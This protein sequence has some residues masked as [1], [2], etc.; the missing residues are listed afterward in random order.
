VI[1]DEDDARCIEVEDDARCIRIEDDV[2]SIEDAY[3]IVRVSTPVNVVEPISSTPL[4]T[5]IDASFQ[6]AWLRVQVQ[7]HMRCMICMYIY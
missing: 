2:G 4:I 7:M 3:N 1:E 5:T 6:E